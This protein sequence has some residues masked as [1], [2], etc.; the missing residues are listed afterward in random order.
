MTSGEDGDVGSRGRALK[1]GED[2]RLAISRGNV[3]AVQRILDG[4]TVEPL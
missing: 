3:D 4:G 2:L 1:V